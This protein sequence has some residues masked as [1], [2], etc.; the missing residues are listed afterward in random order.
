MPAE[1]P[2]LGDSLQIDQA[3]VGEP[4]LAPPQVSGVSFRLSV[5]WMEAYRP[6]GEVL[7]LQLLSPSGLIWAPEPSAGA[8]FV[9]RGQLSGLAAPTAGAC[10]QEAVAF[11][12][13]KD[14]SV[15][16]PGDG[17]AYLITV[18]N[19]LGEEGTFGFAEAGGMYTERAGDRCP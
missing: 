17:F 10:W 13:I 6:P 8:Y 18:R 9:Y 3:A 16:A 14:A 15:P 5:G 7:D 4:V 19:R 11:N 2:L 12:G 1:E